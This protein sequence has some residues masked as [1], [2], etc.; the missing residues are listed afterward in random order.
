[1]T[2]YSRR[3]H[4]T[5]FMRAV[6]RHLSGVFLASGDR[7][8]RASPEHWYCHTSAVSCKNSELELAFSPASLAWRSARKHT[9]CFCFELTPAEADLCLRK[10]P[11][12]RALAPGS[13]LGC[14]TRPRQCQLWTPMSHQANVLAGGCPSDSPKIKAGSSAHTG[15]FS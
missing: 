9:A 11:A 2:I 7:D 13:A 5:G 6:L 8:T 3:A 12:G 14:D 1:M 4:T 10:A 15:G